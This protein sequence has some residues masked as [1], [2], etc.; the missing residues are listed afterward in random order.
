MTVPGMEAF[1]RTVR[2]EQGR[3][4]DGEGPVTA[5]RAPGRLDVMGGIADYSGSLVL[6]SPLAEAAKVGLQKRRD[7]LLRIRSLGIAREGLAEDCCIPLSDFYSGEGLIAYEA[8]RCLL[9]RSPQTRWAAYLAGAFYALLAEGLTGRFPCGAN[10]LLSSDVPLGAGVSSSAAIEVAAMKAIASVFGIGMDGLTLAR[11]CQVVENRVVGAPCGIMDQ[12]TS[13]LGEAGRLL[14]LKCQPHDLLGQAPLPDGCRVMGINSH[15]KHS[16][17]GSRYT[18][19]RVAAFMG[20]KILTE[21]VG[22][23]P[24]GGYLA[25]IA[26]QEYRDRYARLLPSRI[27]GSEFLARYGETSD[28]VTAIDP[29]LVPVTRAFPIKLGQERR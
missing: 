4:F 16:V 25:N 22:D 17:G 10:L 14:I 13:A 1:I 6:E 19:V 18:R 7:G 27:K 20:L 26:P 28:P 21:S 12:V 29:A 2:S 15:V 9:T 23:D 3:F 11:L 5:A 8:V 24:W